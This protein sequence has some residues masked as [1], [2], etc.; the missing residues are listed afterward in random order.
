MRLRVSRGRFCIDGRF[1]HCFALAKERRKQLLFPR[2]F[3]PVLAGKRWWIC[4]LGRFARPLA[5]EV[6]QFQ[7]L[8]VL[9]NF[10]EKIDKDWAMVAPFDVC[11]DIR[12][13]DPFLQTRRDENVVDA[14]T[15]IGGTRRKL[16]VPA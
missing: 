10:V 16:G 13:L 14:S 2:V 9:L 6:A 7:D 5:Q 3:V 4:W 12:S 15:V 8:P 11:L 1:L